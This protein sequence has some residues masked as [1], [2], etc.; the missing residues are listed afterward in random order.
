M[1]HENFWFRTLFKLKI[2]EV[3][4]ESFQKLFSDIAGYRYPGFQAVAPYGN[5]GDGG[6]DGWVPDENRY[7]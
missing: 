6:N 7:F 3:S 4:G 5:Q 1:S 2:Y